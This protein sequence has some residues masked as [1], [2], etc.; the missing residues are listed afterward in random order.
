MFFR[1]IPE[2][3]VAS[4]I[5][6]FTSAYDKGYPKVI[7]ELKYFIKI[8]E[9]DI[10]GYTSYVDMGNFYFVGNTYIAPEYRGEGHYSQLL[11]DRNNHLYDK[12]K[13]ALVNPMNDTDI[14]ILRE[15]V[16]KQGGKPVY[17]YTQVSD[18]MSEGVYA[19]LA[20]LPMYIY[21]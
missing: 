18:I 7:P 9:Q 3:I 14:N 21:R 5:P 4:N 8:E 20:E 2:V 17:C 16:N 12:P 15:Q 11:A 1:D 6:N 13:V 10:A 19:D